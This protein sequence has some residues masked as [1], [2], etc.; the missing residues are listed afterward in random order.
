MK[1]IA[2]SSCLAFAALS[3]YAADPQAASAQPQHAGTVLS[4]AQTI[5]IGDS[6]LVRAAKSTNRLNKKPGQ[7]ITNETL[8]HAGGH[9]TTAAVQPPLPIVVAGGAG[10]SMDH[11]SSPEEAWSTILSRHT[12]PTSD[13]EP[14][15][16]AA[17]RK[18]EPPVLPEAVSSPGTRT[19]G[20]GSG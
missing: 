5:G 20:P 11:A 17:H 12:H 3:L 10:K 16:S 6:P 9:F 18:R 19:I 1:P 15:S 8:V 13:L 2:I 7:V 14:D 4:S